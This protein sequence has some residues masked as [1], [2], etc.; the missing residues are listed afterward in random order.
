MENLCIFHIS[1][2]LKELSFLRESTSFN[3]SIFLNSL[4]K[5]LQNSLFKLLQNSIFKPLQNSIFKLLQD[6]IFKL[7]Q[8]SISK[9]YLSA[10]LYN[11]LLS[12]HLQILSPKFISITQ[13][14]MNC[15]LKSCTNTNFGTS[16]FKN[17]HVCLH[18]EWKRIS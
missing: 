5:L 12:H 3:N 1:L 8:N 10:H 16:G 11:Q 9:Y 17:R 2:I 18:C 6:S 15:H 14:F 13:R 4:F 7:L